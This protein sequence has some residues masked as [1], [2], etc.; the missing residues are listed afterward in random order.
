MVDA[1]DDEV[2]EVSTSLYFLYLP[3]IFLELDS[4]NLFSPR[5]LDTL[6]N[7]HPTSHPLILSFSTVNNSEHNPSL[8][9]QVCHTN[10]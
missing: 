10:S 3:A 8:N 9:D 6:A 5:S 2:R 7:E 4:F 1:Q